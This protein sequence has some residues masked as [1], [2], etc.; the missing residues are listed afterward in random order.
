MAK[1]RAKRAASAD[2]LLGKE[3]LLYINYGDSATEAKPAWCLIGGQTTADLDMSADSIDATN[4]A[5]GGWGET[6][7]GIKKTEL[8][9]EGVICKSDD[10]YAAMKDAFI[11]SES[12]DVCRYASDGTAD[13]NW[14]N[15]TELKDSTPHDDTATFT[16]T[17]NGLGAPTFYKG[18]DTVDKVTGAMKPGETVDASSTSGASSGV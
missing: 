6:Y 8:S 7:A 5:S 11:K 3:V 1:E 17:L 12:V 9:L 14:Y 13:R 15:I 18:A 10:G 4:K 2:K 16:V